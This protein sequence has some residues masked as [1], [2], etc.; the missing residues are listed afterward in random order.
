MASVLPEA[1]T[2]RAQSELLQAEWSEQTKPYQ[3]LDKSGGVSLCPKACIAEVIRRV[4]YSTRPTALLT[5]EDPDVLGIRGFPHK[6]VS[7]TLSV[8]GAGGIG[9]DKLVQRYLVQ[10]G[11]GDH[12]TQRVYGSPVQVF[13]TMCSMIIKLPVRHGWPSGPIP[14]N[15]YVSE[16]VKHADAA[17]I[18]ELQ[19]REAQS[20]SFLLHVDS[21]KVFLAKS[22]VN[23]MFIKERKLDDGG[24]ELELLWLKKEP[25]SK[26][27]Y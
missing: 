17:A 12:V 8:M 25:A 24:N 13:T 10:I 21:V 15:V 5:T 11:Y 1:A 23:G 9:Q 6:L 18:A 26:Q 2:V 20:A 3:Q 7:C 14:G 22:G 4:G 27:R 19:P 16:L